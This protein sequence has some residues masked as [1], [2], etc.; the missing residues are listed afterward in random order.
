MIPRSRHHGKLVCVPY[1]M[2]PARDRSD[3]EES[4]GLV[5]SGVKK[6]ILFHE[7]EAEALRVRAFKDR[8]SESSIVREALR[9]FLKV[10]D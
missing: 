1:P 4:R 9:R 8:R 2:M 5:K 7:D 3:P 6:T 10:P